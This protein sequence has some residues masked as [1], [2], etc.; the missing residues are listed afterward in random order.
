MTEPWLRDACSRVDAVRARAL[1]AART[2]DVSQPFGGVPFAVEEPEPVE[3][4]S[5]PRGSELLEGAVARSP[6]CR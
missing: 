4:R 5:S 6:W 3:G 1:A 2:A